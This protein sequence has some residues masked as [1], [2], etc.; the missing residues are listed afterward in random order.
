MELRTIQ[1]KSKDHNGETVVINERDFDEKVHTRVT[2][3]GEAY[4]FGVQAEYGRVGGQP[5][6]E[7]HK[8]TG[9][10][11]IERNLPPT[12]VDM[13]SDWFAPQN[14]GLLHG[15]AGQQEK[16]QRIAEATRMASIT[17]PEGGVVSEALKA[18][19]AVPPSLASHEPPRVGVEAYDPA[20]VETTNVPGDVV[21]NEGESE[22]GASKSKRTNKK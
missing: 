20:E 19:Q 9:Q 1:V 18:G 16:E 14:G 11:A 15:I 3:E 21:E 4:R 17:P 8:P 7:P 2:P 10:G 22:S 13:P 5:L 6:V 12:G